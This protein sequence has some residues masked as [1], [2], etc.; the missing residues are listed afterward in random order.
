[1]YHLSLSN[2]PKL[3]IP[4]IPDNYMTKHGYENNTVR[5]ICLS[6]SIDGCLMAMSSNIKGKTF[7]IM[8]PENMEGLKVIRNEEIVK[9]GYVPDAKLTG[10]TWIL[11]SFKPKVV[12]EVTV[13]GPVEDGGYEYQYGDKTAKLYKWNYDMK[14]YD[15]SINE[16]TK[17]M[18][19]VIDNS[20]DAA[21]KSG[22]WKA[23]G[24]SFYDQLLNAFYCDG[25]IP[26]DSK[27]LEKKSKDGKYLQWNDFLKEAYLVAPVKSIKNSPYGVTPYSKSGC[28]YPH[29][30]IRDGKLVLSVPGL[31]AAYSRAKQM[32]VFSGE[33]KAH[34]ERHYKELGMYE[35]SAMYSEKTIEQNFRDIEKVIYEETGIDLHCPTTLYEEEIE[36]GSIRPLMRDDVT[37]PYFVEWLFRS[38][39]FSDDDP[40]KFDYD[41]LVNND[42]IGNYAYGY[43]VNG[44]LE[45]II[46]VKHRKPEDY[47]AI[48]MLFVNDEVE[49]NGIGQTLMRYVINKFGDKEMRL[50]VF[51]FNSR[52]MHIYKKYGFDIASSGVA[53]PEANGDSNKLV[54]KKFYKMVRK[55][56]EYDP[57]LEFDK[58]PDHLKNDPIHAWRAKSGI[59]LIHREP[60]LE[61]L[62]RI[63][64]N[65]QLMSDEQK[66]ISDKKSMEL[67]GKNNHDHYMELVKEYNK[68]NDKPAI[69]IF[70]SGH[71]SENKED[72][73]IINTPED[74]LEWMN[75]IQYGWTDKGGTVRGTG[76]D[77]DESIFF[78]QYR[79]QSPIQLS[80]SCV[81]VCWD[82]TELERS[83]FKQH[84]YPNTVVYVEIDDGNN[85][86]S[87]SFLIY[88]DP[89]ENSTVYWFEHS[90]GQYRGIHKYPDL[91]S[92]MNDA[93]G[94]CITSFDTTGKKIIRNMN[95]PPRYGCSCDEFM[96][97]AHG[98]DIIDMGDLS[99]DVMF[100]EGYRFTSI[101][102]IKEHYRTESGGN[103]DEDDLS[104]ITA[105]L[106]E[107][108][109]KENGPDNEK[110]KITHKDSRYKGWTEYAVL[111]KDGK[112]AASCIINSKTGDCANVETKPEYRRQGYM[113]Y[114]L[115]YLV[116]F[117]G[118]KYAQVQRD[119]RIAISLY[120]KIG[121]E[122]EFSY[123]DKDKG[124]M[125]SMAF[126]GDTSKLIVE[127]YD[128]FM[129]AD[130]PPSMP[131]DDQVGTEEPTPEPEKESMPK[132][133]DKAES[134]KNGVRRKKLYIAFIE[135]CKEYNNKNTF[136]SIFD[137]DAFNVS[138]PFV[139]DE[140]RYFYR[141]AN[142][143]LCVLAGDLT[144]FPASE[145]RKLNSKNSHLNEMMI[146]A[147]TPNDVRVFNVKDKKIYIGTEE[148]GA[149]KLGVVLG[150]TF[151]LYIQKMINK[152]DILNA[153]LEESVEFYE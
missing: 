27:E 131:D 147:A 127:G 51:E 84:G 149:L 15:E 40:E 45:G 46:K 64:A 11:N 74:L 133:T 141:L 145:L 19:I 18:Q 8:T 76:E 32:G 113:Q 118:V 3:M 9:R 29:H 150:D 57:P 39:E 25:D 47:Y 60:T 89:G 10:E 66:A 92:C 87:H 30:V 20:K 58:L 33:V 135:W 104:W 107:D 117:K 103:M 126:N 2:K 105:Y 28:K 134:S 93:I 86:P 138:Y 52:A 63:W 119:N 38:Y 102:D 75:C 116:K 43:F 26:T 54:G 100:N 108:V 143:M 73:A 137:K 22:K 128:M 153:P 106:M 90:W 72:L 13:I 99:Y 88:K 31:Q 49:S 91:K 96:N 56:T 110:Y 59:E 50:N 123:T 94:K 82:Q 152:G 97:H 14:W 81:G 62:N 55:P 114:L 111:N 1:M 122:V 80:R 83:W 144:F 121:F 70:P 65:W 112:E 77:D 68:T 151:D 67:F 24:A 146:F 42:A 36:N 7:Y 142:P 109:D 17:F 129:E 95:I 44:K 5:R 136:G 6:T 48:S 23:P 12:G 140:M 78:K 148:N 16:S 79:L 71:F 53:Q 124:P 101:N 85:C 115:K 61:E 69:S 35:D 37:N 41:M 132:K 120:R 21:I 4:T 98:S 130:E 34:L 139:P 125:Y